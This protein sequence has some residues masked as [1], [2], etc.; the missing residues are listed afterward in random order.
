M[1]PADS[2][3]SR[4]AALR[5]LAAV[6]LG[7][8]ALPTLAGVVAC[9][10]K[11]PRAIAYGRDECAWCRMTVSDARFGAVL[12]TATGR[13]EVFD[14]VECLAAATLALDPSEQPRVMMR[15]WVTDWLHPRALV[16]APS[17]RY[18]Q[19]AGP[20]S[21][22]GKGLQAFS[23][24]ANAEAEQRRSGG[25]LMSWDEVLDMAGGKHATRG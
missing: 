17:A 6:T 8:A 21:P 13:Q 9:A 3:I 15:S 11:G 14:S 24:L 5:R 12:L 2:P 20:G 1:P 18:L 25:L 7:A 22:M 10:D 19:N 16:Q 23:S 4:R